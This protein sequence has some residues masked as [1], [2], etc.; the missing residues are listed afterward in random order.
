VTR[1]AKW[2]QR[3]EKKKCE[4]GIKKQQRK[5]KKTKIKENKER[6]NSKRKQNQ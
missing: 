4:T 2:E 3:E 1:E 5:N 6:E